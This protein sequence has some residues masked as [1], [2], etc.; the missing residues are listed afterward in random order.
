MPL[1]REKPPAFLAIKLQD[2]WE[3]SENLEGWVKDAYADG[4]LVSVS[5]NNR[6][7]YVARIVDGATVEYVPQGSYLVATGRK[8]MAAD[9]ETFEAKY[10]PI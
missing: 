8:L 4:R 3:Q 7:A 1:Y 2:G 9:P 10:E 6:S 5:S